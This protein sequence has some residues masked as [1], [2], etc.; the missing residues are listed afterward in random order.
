MTQPI[1]RSLKDPIVW[2]HGLFFFNMFLY[3]EKGYFVIA[4][5]L[6]FNILFS[7]FYHL[8]HEEDD[9]WEDLD[10]IFCRITLGAI[11]WYVIKSCTM[12]QI[13]LCVVWLLISLIFLELG[14][15]SNYKIFH[16]L[17][18]FMVFGGNLIVWS[19]LPLLH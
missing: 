11:A 18:H 4:G 8:T 17:W 2:T 3:I 5:V 10:L 9:L 1:T 16:S 15:W 13:I 19:Y 12:L 14:R 6:F 7:L